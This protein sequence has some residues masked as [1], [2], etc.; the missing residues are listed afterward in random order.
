M[1]ETELLFTDVLGCSRQ[2][3]Y[4]NK[5]KKIDRDKL[6]FISLALKRRIKSEP[7]Q[8][9]LGKA[10]FM[11]LE[12][13][14][15]ADVLIPRQE[16]EILVETVIKEVQECRSAGVQECERLKILDLGTGSGCIAVSLAKLL[17]NVEIIAADISQKAIAIAE[18]N[19]ILNSV[20]EKIKFV[21]TDLFSGLR[22]YEPARYDII[23]TNP[24]YVLSGEIDT[25]QP[26]IKYE[27][28]VALDGGNDG[29]D[30]YRQLIREAPVYLKK[31]GLLI[32]EIGFNQ[33]SA[34][35]NIFYGLKKF[36]IIEVIKDYS[37]IDRVIVA[38]K[39]R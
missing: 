14:V 29:L 24:P 21:N 19:A 34:I 9:I 12:F 4:L 32:M 31:G 35:E 28:R 17:Q 13:K 2:D 8:Y 39:I 7:I 38:K 22:I 37:N 26:E 3:L 1:D 6:F 36:E 5:D 25:L 15:T 30:V 18:D 10:D 33:K 20:A 16:T 11:G 27:P 23:V